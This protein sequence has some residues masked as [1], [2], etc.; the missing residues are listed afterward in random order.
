MEYKFFS[1]YKCCYI[2]GIINLPI[3]LI[4]YFIVS[5]APCNSY[6]LCNDETGENEHFDDIFKLFK[7]IKLYDVIILPIYSICLGAGALL[8]NMTMN[9]FT[10]YHIIIPI[11]IGDFFEKIIDL[12]E[13]GEENDIILLIF[14][15]IEFL[16]YLIFLE[17]IEL[18]CCGLN[19]NTRKNIGIRAISKVETE[20]ERDSFYDLKDIQT[21]ENDNN[22]QL[23]PD[24]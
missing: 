16:F 2:I 8:I 15:I 12:F 14:F 1:P 4:I 21:D 13:K 6:F 19:K 20:N 10:F 3:I 11:R 9:D 23:M 18:N 24:N 17:I 5:Y 7:E 22:E